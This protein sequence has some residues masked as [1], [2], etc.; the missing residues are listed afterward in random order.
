M[1]REVFLE[2]VAFED[3]EEQGCDFQGL[4]EPVKLH[5]A[6]PAL[7]PGRQWCVEMESSVIKARSLWLWFS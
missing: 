6:V 1:G 2:E 7:G 5:Q 3:G 4:E